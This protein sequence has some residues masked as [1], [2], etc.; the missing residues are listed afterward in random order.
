MKTIKK[1]ASIPYLGGI[2]LKLSQTVNIESVLEIG[3]TIINS[4]LSYHN[5]G[6]NTR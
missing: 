1:K 4:R 3:H 6:R 5:R 2:G